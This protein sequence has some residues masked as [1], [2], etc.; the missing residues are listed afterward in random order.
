M[1]PRISEARIQRYFNLARQASK[2]SHMHRARVG[3]VFVYKNKVLSAGWNSDKTAPIQAYWNK[4][5]FDESKEPYCLHSLHA[6]TTALLNIRHLDIDWSKVTVFNWRVKKDES[7][8][9]SRPCKSCMAMLMAQGIKDVFYSTDNG[10]G[11]ERL[12]RS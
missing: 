6:E 8:G 3:S 11:F 10:W 2:Y 12:E 7:Q 4:E 5:R 9:N 1:N